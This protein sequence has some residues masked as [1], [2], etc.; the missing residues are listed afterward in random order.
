M[1]K[2][3]FTLIELIMVI[4]ILGILAVVAI[5]KYFD[6]QSDAKLAAE[7]GVIGGVR[8]GVYTYY[9][10]YRVF[11]A[12]LDNVSSNTTCNSTNPCFA[13]VL[14]QGIT[15]DWQKASATTYTGPANTTYTY[16]ASSGEFK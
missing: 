10:K 9:A 14:M 5:P 7:K 2:K 12:T 15:S 6:L 11:P 8:S 16:N 13:T 3:G 1:T 4:V